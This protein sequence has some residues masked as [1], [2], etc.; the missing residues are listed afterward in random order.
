MREVDYQFLLERGGVPLRELA[1]QGA[2]TIKFQSGAAVMRSLSGTFRHD[3]GADWLRD[4]IRARM[5]LN[6]QWHD[7][8][9]FIVSTLTE[10]WANGASCDRIEA[11]DGGLPVQQTRT[12]GVLHLSAGEAYL[13]AVQRLLMEAGVEAVTADPCADCLATDREDWDEGTS[14]L[15]I[16]NALLGEIGFAPLWFD[17]SGIARLC[18]AA[19]DAGTPAHTYGP[20]DGLIAGPCTVTRDLYAPCNVFKV[21]VSNPDLPAPMTAVSVNDNPASPFSTAS[22]GRR[23]LAP[24]VRLDN[25]ASQEALQARA[26]QLRFQSQLAEEVVTFTTANMPGHRYLDAVA[27]EHE[28]LQGVYQETEWT[29]RLSHD[30]QMTHRARRVLYL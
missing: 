28:R 26:D 7:L 13:S 8:G 22:L 1:A 29:L 15:T 12:E 30:G 18:R 10:S 27:L 9:V 4:R 21:V 11:M 25:I 16:V 3:E 5:K 24:V 23:V 6:G 2:P 17:E 14:Y 19:S 20:R